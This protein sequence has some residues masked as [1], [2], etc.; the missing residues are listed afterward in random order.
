LRNLTSS[1][2][3][4]GRRQVTRSRRA[5]KQMAEL[6]PRFGAT[7]GD[8]QGPLRTVVLSTYWDGTPSEYVP[9][10]AAAGPRYPSA[11]SSLSKDDPALGYLSGDPFDSL[12]SLR[13]G[14][15]RPHGAQIRIPQRL[16]S[17]NHYLRL[18]GAT[19]VA[20]FPIVLAGATLWSTRPVAADDIGI[21]AGGTYLR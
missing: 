11:E 5:K 10:H 16:K 20:P 3:W 4:H 15:I 18:F 17:R 2:L 7:P 13:A 1:R 14:S 8:R 9:N 12:R 21:Y 6:P 19:K